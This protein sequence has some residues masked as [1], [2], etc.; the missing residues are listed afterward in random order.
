ME[1]PIQPEK[2]AA[3]T[4]GLER[5][6]FVDDEPAIEALGKRLLGSLGYDV[7]TCA[8]AADAL[9]LFRSNPDGFDIVITDMTMPEMTGDRM[10][11]EMMRI[12]SDLPV[13]VCNG[14]NELLSTQ[15]VQEVGIRALLMKPFLK[16]EA[17]KII[18]DVLD[19][20]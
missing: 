14:S 7:V 6:L 11:A 4:G 13:I 5:I 15:R 12:R 1:E 16:N 2:E 19:R 20:R 10:A 18:R 9:E 3:A 8:N 17:A